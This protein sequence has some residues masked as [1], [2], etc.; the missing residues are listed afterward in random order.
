LVAETRARRQGRLLEVGLLLSSV[1][2]AWVFW[3]WAAVIEARR[4][5]GLQRE[6]STERLSEDLHQ[7]TAE[8][9]RAAAEVERLRAR[10]A[11]LEEEAAAAAEADRWFDRSDLTTQLEEA[12]ARELEAR[13]RASSLEAQRVQL[14]RERD[15]L[16][17][18]LRELED[19]G[20]D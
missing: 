15:A 8:R 9:D 5:A 4:S 13:H 14:E 18:Q 11:V 6:A 20:A 17:A 16:D 3:Q 1:V 2:L 10:A 19:V 12:R 7:A